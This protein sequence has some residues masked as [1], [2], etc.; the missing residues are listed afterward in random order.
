MQ[1]ISTLHL[2][3]YKCDQELPL[4]VKNRIH[5]F[6]VTLHR[7]IEPKQKSVS[8]CA[9]NPKLPSLDMI[10]LQT[11]LKMPRIKYCHCV[12]WAM[13]IWNGLDN[14]NACG[15]VQRS[16]IQSMPGICSYRIKGRR[17][18]REIEH[19]KATMAQNQ[20]TFIIVL[21][22]FL[23]VLLMKHCICF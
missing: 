18:S 22:P 14:I 20:S 13:T 21:R 12:M 15:C 10:N 23:V 5:S 11:D 2:L 7:H 9:N 16:T 4:C 3:S 6:I 19:G 8:T 1:H 17:M